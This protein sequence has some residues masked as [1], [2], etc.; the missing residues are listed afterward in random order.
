MDGISRYC[1]AASYGLAFGLELL[2]S[3]WTRPL[4]RAI[5]L[6]S[7]GAGLLA[8]TIYLIVQRPTPQSAYGSLLLLAWVLAVFYLY[9]SVH[10]R[11]QAWAIFVLPLVLGLVLLAGQFAPGAAAVPTSWADAVAPLTGDR[12]WGIVHGGLLILS[13]VGVSVGCIASVMYLVQGRRLRS[14]AVLNRGVKMLSLERLET[15][16]R[17]AINVAFPL[18]TVGLAVGAALMSR[19]DA[20]RPDWTAGKF[21]GTFGLWLVVVIL[22]WLRYGVHARGR[23]LALGTIAAF[24]IMVA[25]LAASHPFAEGMP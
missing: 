22:L 11:R 8:H 10:H 14:K 13:A 17:R 7:G 9:G 6:A 18:L 25:V 21:I 23:H 24:A 20:A 2:N 12:F 16:N 4:V 5:G 19:R 1:F 3:V 15:M